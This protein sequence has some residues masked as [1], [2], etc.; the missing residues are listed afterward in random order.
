MGSNAVRTLKGAIARATSEAKSFP[1]LLNSC[2]LVGC[3][4]YIAD[5]KNPKQFFRKKCHGYTSYVQFNFPNSVTVGA[6]RYQLLL[7]I[8][9]MTNLRLAG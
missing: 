5:E 8:I 6:I 9:T 7:I 3:G 4:N 1:E 2:K